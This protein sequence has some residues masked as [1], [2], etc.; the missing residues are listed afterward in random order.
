MNKVK[1]QLPLSTRII[2]VMV[3]VSN[4]FVTFAVWQGLV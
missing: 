4:V 3:I 1:Y 2:L